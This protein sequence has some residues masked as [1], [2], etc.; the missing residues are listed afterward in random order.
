MY[1]GF[2]LVQG[3]LLEEGDNLLLPEDALQAGQSTVDAVLFEALEWVMVAAQPQATNSATGGRLIWS[4]HTSGTPISVV[5][6]R[7]GS[8]D[9]PL[10]AGPACRLT[11][12]CNTSAPTNP[13][14]ASQNL[15]PD[16]H[17]G[18]HL[19]QPSNNLQPAAVQHS[20]RAGLT[21]YSFFRLTKGLLALLC[22]I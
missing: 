11:R 17:I 1:T 15:G 2:V 21:L 8:Q 13:F 10:A 5:M 18:V 19:K 4:A 6:G 12:M 7:P 22:Q 20:S 3:H 16:H 9:V 14:H